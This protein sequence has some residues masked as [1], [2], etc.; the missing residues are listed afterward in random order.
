MEKE[1]F[2]SGTLEGKRVDLYYNKYPF[3]Q[4]HGLLVPEREQEN[5]QLLT[6]SYHHYL[7]QTASAMATTLP[8]SGFG[9]NSYGAYASVNHLHFQMFLREQPFP[10]EQPQWSHNGCSIGNGCSRRNI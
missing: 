4:G 3:T 9:Y 10:I 5:P 2:W 6:E 1:I 7:C 8:G